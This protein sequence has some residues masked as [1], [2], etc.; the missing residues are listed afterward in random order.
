MGSFDS[1]YKLERSLIRVMV[2]RLYPNLVM[3]Y[4]WN[5]FQLSMEPDGNEK[6]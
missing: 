1:T 4:S 6:Y 3:N 5:M 2:E